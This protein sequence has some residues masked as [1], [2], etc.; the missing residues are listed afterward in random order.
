M[1]I[2]P[3]DP[4]VEYRHWYLI[5]SPFNLNGLNSSGI[6]QA[7]RTRKDVMS[8]KEITLYKQAKSKL[9]QILAGTNTCED[10][11]LR[12]LGLCLLEDGWDSYAYEILAET[13]RRQH[14]TKQKEGS[15]YKT[16]PLFSYLASE[17]KRIYIAKGIS[18]TQCEPDQRS[19]TSLANYRRQE[20]EKA[21]RELIGLF[22]ENMAESKNQNETEQYRSHKKEVAKDIKRRLQSEYGIV[23]EVQ[24]AS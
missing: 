20:Q 12:L 5:N 1:S 16:M 23:L 17:V 8:E 3:T 13:V 18:W 9:E 14:T 19:Y 15:G 11:K 10:L 24:R 22:H 4:F 6:S 7:I 2:L 21:A